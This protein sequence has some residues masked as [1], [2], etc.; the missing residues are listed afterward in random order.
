MVKIAQMVEKQGNLLI[1]R[2]KRLLFKFLGAIYKNM[3][4]NITKNS[5]FKFKVNSKSSNLQV[6]KGV[7]NLAN[8]IFTSL[9]NL[10]YFSYYFSKGYMYA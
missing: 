7:K 6:C 4:I 8:S 9:Q 10:S 1:L 5:N 2:I 3:K